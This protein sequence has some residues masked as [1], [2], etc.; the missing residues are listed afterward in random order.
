LNSQRLALSHNGKVNGDAQSA[1]FTLGG[2]Q[3]CREA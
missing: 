3:T 1:Q 2:V